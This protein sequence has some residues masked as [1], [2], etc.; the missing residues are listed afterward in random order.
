MALLETIEFG[1][2]TRRPLTGVSDV[3]EARSVWTEFFRF[4]D[5]SE[6]RKSVHGG[7]PR[8][9]ERVVVANI[10]SD[11]V[12]AHFNILANPTP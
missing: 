3:T 6:Q 2:R 1:V 12:A 10:G 11:L 4:A 7:L 9:E 5:W 8:C